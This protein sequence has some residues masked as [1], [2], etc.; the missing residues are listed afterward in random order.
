[1]DRPTLAAQ[2]SHRLKTLVLVG[3]AGL[4]VAEHPTTDIFSLKPAELPAYL[5][6]D[7]SVLA[8]Y[9]PEP[10]GPEFLDFL[11]NDYHEM[12]SFARLAWERPS[13]PNLARWLHRIS[14]PTLLLYGEKDRITPA[15][16]SKTWA[17]LIPERESA[18]R[19]GRGPPG[20]R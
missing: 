2:N 5:A 13:D 15:A 9:V 20:A 12:S 16:Q 19:Q 6:N 7:L 4:R 18:H 8:P 11:V 14:V 10:G 3:P 1:M 17:G